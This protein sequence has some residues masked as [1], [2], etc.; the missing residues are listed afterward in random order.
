MH[1][2]RGEFI[3]GETA[4]LQGDTKEAVYPLA[5]FTESDPN[6]SSACHLFCERTTL[7]HAR[8]SPLEGKH[9]A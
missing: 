6:R 9:A 3:S 7:R 4:G 1:R 8:F 2:E 5:L